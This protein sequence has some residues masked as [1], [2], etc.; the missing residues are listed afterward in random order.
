MRIAGKQNLTGG[1]NSK[2]FANVET[3]GAELPNPAAIAG[4]VVTN[5]ERIG[6]PKVGATQIALREAGDV[7][8]AKKISRH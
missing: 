7:Y 6:V 4:N 2:G 8:V 1:I 3:A 5:E